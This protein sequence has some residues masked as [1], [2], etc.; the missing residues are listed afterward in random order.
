MVDVWAMGISHPSVVARQAARSEAAGYDGMFVVDSQNL[1]GDPFVGLTIA[2]RETTRL[3]LGTGVTNPA[4]RHPA[5]AAA[6][7]ASVHLASGGRAVLGIGRGDSALAHVGL[8]PVSVER[9]ERFVAVT[10]AYLWGESVSFDDLALFAP[11]RVAPVAALGLADA[12]ETSRLHWLPTDLAPV[13]VEVVGTGP[14]VLDA[15]A[16]TADRVVLAVGADPERVGWAIDRV[17]ATNASVPIGAFVNVVAHPDLGIARQLIAGG[18]S[19]FARF[20]V[21]HGNVPTPMSDTQRSTLSN[22]HRVYDMNRHTQG[23]SPQ[24]AQLDPDFIDRFGIAGPATMCVER[25]QELAKL[26]I[27]RFVVVGPTTGVDRDAASAA[28]RNFA[29]E[30]LPALR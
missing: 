12:P 17:R 25:L 30:V 20:S 27:D 1:A 22:V 5:A 24:A 15:A 23:G 21:M 13:P 9:L 7:I 16:R 3:Q 26:G 28:G 10:R 11:H 19:T 2:A 6:A 18:M 8:A 4:M 29:E 14:K